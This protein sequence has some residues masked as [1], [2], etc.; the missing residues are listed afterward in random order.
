MNFFKPAQKG[1]I[2]HSKFEERFW[3]FQRQIFEKAAASLF[4]NND[5]LGG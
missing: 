5:Y 3:K 4:V 1:K 2:P